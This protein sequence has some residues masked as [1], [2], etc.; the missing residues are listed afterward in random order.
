MRT[1]TRHLSLSLVL[2][3]ALSLAGCAPEPAP[4][5][6]ETTA[7]TD[8]PVFASDAEALAAATEAY[9]AYLAMSDKI[10]AEG[11]NDP[12]RIRAFASQK[13]AEIEMEGYANFRSKGLKSVGESRFSDL[14]LQDESP[15]DIAGLGAVTTYLCS[16]VSQV[17]V[18]DTNGVSVVAD[19]R[20]DF[21]PFI[22]S[23]DLVSRDPV[24]LIVASADVWEG[25]GVCT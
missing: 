6:S 21:T 4:Q 20:P 22:V 18:V 14:I 3:A 9:A 7:P 17:D 1:V 15:S 8:A 19:S 23:F 16:D 25:A 5:A 2:L 10:L 13:L 12:D 24:A 11:G